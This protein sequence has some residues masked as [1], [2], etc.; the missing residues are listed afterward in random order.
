[1]NSVFISEYRNAKHYVNDRKVLDNEMAITYDGSHADILSKHNNTV[2]Y[3]RLNNNDLRKLL[4]IDYKHDTSLVDKLE[5]LLPSKKHKT[6]KNRRKHKKKHTRKT[7]QAA[8]HRTYKKR[9][10]SRSKQ[11]KTRSRK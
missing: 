10:K 3:E 5:K 4:D 9:S 1:M 6:R 8:K 2:V 7:K 11:S